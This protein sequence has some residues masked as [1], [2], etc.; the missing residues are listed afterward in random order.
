MIHTC[1]ECG[2]SMDCEGR[3]GY[4]SACVGRRLDLCDR[5]ENERTDLLAACEYVVKWHREHDSGE[6]ELFGQDF[7][8]TCIAA[9]ALTEPK[10][11]NEHGQ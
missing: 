2:H 1:L 6:G 10:R 9:I 5:L 4:C 11:R 8:T 3:N 7:V